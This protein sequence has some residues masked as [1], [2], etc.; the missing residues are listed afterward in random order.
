VPLT[1]EQFRYAFAN[2]VDDE[3]RQLYETYAVPASAR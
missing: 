1:Y 2:A 3:A